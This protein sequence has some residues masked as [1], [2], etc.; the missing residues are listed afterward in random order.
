MNT[1]RLVAVLNLPGPVPKLLEVGDTAH[2]SMTASTLLSTC[3]NPTPAGFKTDL[4]AL[5]AAQAI[6]GNGPAAI[7]AR[8]DAQKQVRRD[9]I[10]YRIFVQQSADANE[11]Q[12]A[13]IIASAGLALKKVTARTKPDL[14]IVQGATIGTAIARAKSRGPRATYWWSSSTDQKAWVSAPA[15]R[16]AQATFAGLTPGTMYYFRFQVLTKAG[17]SDWSQVVGFMVK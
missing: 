8:N 9:M 16:I 17:L 10:N 6:K 7:S 3:T 14:A 1:K 11:A 15:T 13:T 5:R 2:T 4:D 12:A